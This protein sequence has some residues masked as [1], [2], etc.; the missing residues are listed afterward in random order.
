MSFKN[1]FRRDRWMWHEDVILPV[2]KKKKRK[3]KFYKYDRKD[4]KKFINYFLS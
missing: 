3:R 1:F 4:W 2:G